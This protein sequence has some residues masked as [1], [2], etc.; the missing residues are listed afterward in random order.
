MIFELATID[1][2][3]ES[4]INKVKEKQKLE[5]L[6]I[7]QTATKSGLGQK[8]YENFLYNG[9]ITLV[10]L[11]KLLKTLRLTKELENLINPIEARDDE[12]YKKLLK[13]RESRKKRKLKSDNLEAFHNFESKELSNV[14]KVI[15]NNK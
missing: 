4:I 1:E 7:A 6:T 9:H 10:N 2:I 11:I 15:R 12:E 5:G 14:L 8:S 13:I 3:M